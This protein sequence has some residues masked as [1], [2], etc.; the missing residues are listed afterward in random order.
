[1]KGRRALAL[2][3]LA[4][5]VAAVLAVVAIRDYTPPLSPVEQVPTTWQTA[6]EAPMH[7]LHVGSKKIA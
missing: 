2:L 1:M 7:V 3:V 5:V 4:L 6:R